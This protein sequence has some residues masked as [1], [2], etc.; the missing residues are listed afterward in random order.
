MARIRTLKPLFWTDE[1][2]VEATMPAR[3]FF[4][5]LLNFADDNGNQPFSARQLKMQIFPA[6]TIDCAPLIDELLRFRLVTRYEVGDRAY[7]HINGFAK[8][9]VINRKGKSAI[10]EPPHSLNG[11]ASNA[12]GSMNEIASSDADSVND[13]NANQSASLNEGAA[14]PHDSGMEK[15]GEKEGKRSKPKSKTRAPAAP[16][17]LPVWVP[18]GPWANFLAMR[19]AQHKTP[20]LHAKKL[21]IAELDRLRADGDDPRAVLER[22]TMNS[23]QGL[24]PLHGS[25]AA[26]RAKFDPVEY[27]NGQRRTR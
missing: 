20:T 26:K 3:L 8:H 13:S 5:G 6:D 12:A 10:P 18:P 22:S 11:D 4:I 2:I 23:W 1:K 27:V 16:F 17:L 7:L 24:F 14:K 25:P 19:R 9:Q 15:E 21:L